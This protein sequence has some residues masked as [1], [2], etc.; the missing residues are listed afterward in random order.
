VPGVGS[1]PSADSFPAYL[2]ADALYPARCANC[3]E[4]KGLRLAAS[5]RRVDILAVGVRNTNRFDRVEVK[6]CGVWTRPGALS[7][8]YVEVNSLREAVVVIEG[9]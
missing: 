2:T 8:R 3:A 5:I 6:M 7:T 1:V 4:E 9:V